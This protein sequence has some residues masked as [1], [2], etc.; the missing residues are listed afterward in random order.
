MP[1]GVIEEKKQKGAKMISS[2]PSAF[3]RKK[4]RG[5]GSGDLFAAPSELASAWLVVS[6]H[7]LQYITNPSPF[8]SRLP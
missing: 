1:D 6:P 5:A 8:F 4:D 3:F 7:R 2:C